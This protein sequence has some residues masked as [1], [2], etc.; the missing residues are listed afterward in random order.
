MYNLQIKYGKKPLR[1]IRAYSFLKKLNMMKIIQNE[2]EVSIEEQE[3]I[4]I[5]QST[6][7]RKYCQKIIKMKYRFIIENNK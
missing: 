4:Y 1:Y 6:R 3:Y 2:D 7:K 5:T